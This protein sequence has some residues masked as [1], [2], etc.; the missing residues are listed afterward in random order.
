MT[1][2][3]DGS[4]AVASAATPDVFGLHAITNGNSSLNVPECCPANLWAIYKSS[5]LSKSIDVKQIVFFLNDALFTIDPV[6]II[7]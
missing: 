7:N 4:I 1:V 5:M 2:G 3:M 6:L